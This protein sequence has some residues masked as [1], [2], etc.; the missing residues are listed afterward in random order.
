MGARIA[1]YRWAETPLGDL[2]D[3]D[4]PLRQAV[5]LIVGSAIPMS[6]VW[7][8]D[9][10]LL[11]NDACRELYG[12]A[13][14]ASSLGKPAAQAW[15]GPDAGFDELR[16]V[17]DSGS[18][19]LA[20]NKA[21]WLDRNEPREPSYLTFGHAPLQSVA[22]E[23]AGVLTVF[24]ENEELATERERAAH[25]AE[26]GEAKSAF[27]AALSHEFRTPLALIAA[28]LEQALDERATLPRDVAK[29]L[30]VARVNV[31][32]LTRMV[33]ALLDF[34]RLEATRVV[35]NLSR[36]DLVRFTRGLAANFAPAMERAG[37]D[38][39]AEVDDA[40][41]EVSVDQDMYE[42][43]VLNL[44][45]N[46]LKYTP[47]GAVRF[48]LTAD[49]PAHYLVA[50]TDTG[51]GIAPD[52]QGRVFER[53]ERVTAARTSRTTTGAGI[54]LAMVKELTELLGGTVE[55]ESAPDV[56]STFRVRLPRAPERP[57]RPGH[58]I[59][60]RGVDSFVAEIDQWQPSAER[61]S[62]GASHAHR[63]KLVLVEDAPDLTEYLVDLLSDT[64]DVVAFPDAEGAVEALRD[65]GAELLLSDMRLPGMDG[66]ELT[67]LVRA[68]PALRDLPVL[69]LSSQA[70]GETSASAL[71]AGADDY[72][73]KPFIP[74]DLRARLA[75]KLNQAKVRSMDSAWRRAV[76]ATL[77]EAVMIFD[78]E[79]LV[80]EVNDAFTQLFGY[81]LD[82]GPLRPPYPW[83]PTREE[84]PAAF[85]AVQKIYA[86]AERGGPARAELMMFTRDRKPI[87]V[88]TTGA[89][90]NNP[91]TGASIHI[92]TVRDVTRARAAQE[93]RT[94]A[95]QVSA[96]F[97]SIDDLA[98]LMGVARH[99]LELL[100]DG[101]CTIQLTLSEGSVL[102]SRGRV[103]EADE[104]GEQTRRGLAGK[105]SPD[106]VS[107]RPG[108]LLVA[109]ASTQ[110]RAWVQFPKPRR[111]G[112]DE[113]I[114]A[115]LL[116]QALALAVDRLLSSKEAAEREAGLVQALASHRL[117][118]QAVGILVE[119]HRL[120]P[121][122]AFDKLR[123]ASQNRNLK[124]RDLAARVIETGSDPENA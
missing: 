115:D 27:F 117:I 51:V 108:I 5:A 32:R 34:S 88:N 20:L 1:E 95:A 99:G 111:I 81:G 96:D 16:G 39:T 71:L 4:E 6:V 87:W 74:H 61:T 17:V 113:M 66:V 54:G 11:Y 103:V 47:A 85:E 21:V 76:I 43:I 30:T 89:T 91:E 46:A 84:D 63:P 75:A 13:R 120:L 104:L 79:G 118:G 44:L 38:F 52:D 83:W 53:F 70:D 102:F 3:W 49:G 100:F 90:V 40:V 65:G 82:D 93:R 31:A 62:R 98:T 19:F 15:P 116:A 123:R 50:V 69:V 68:D 64:Y 37:L 101:E 73:V 78:S 60:P 36:L 9:L 107:L 92:R 25:V 58:S 105:P 67:A 109:S 42:R 94:A 72:V 41:G 48:T 7:G 119:R 10:T 112:P 106:T 18:P 26:L 28:P 24:L 56:G 22:G 57:D 12:A 45:S 121:A 86:Q 33:D 122:Q 8:P 14:Y 23:T 29:G 55:L 77:S 97:S 110:C 114:V 59:T 2:A 124:V 80:I 35:P